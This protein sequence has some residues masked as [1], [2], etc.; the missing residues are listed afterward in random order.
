MLQ[1]YH[2]KEKRALEIPL[3]NQ[4]KY[5]RTLFFASKTYFYLWNV[6]NIGNIEIMNSWNSYC[7]LN[8]LQ[9]WC[10]NFLF[11]VSV[12]VQCAFICSVKR[13]LAFSNWAGPRHVQPWKSVYLLYLKVN[14]LTVNYDNNYKLIWSFS[15]SYLCFCSL[16]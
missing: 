4:W 15:D 12:N 1:G 2:D 8:I 10:K 9:Q 6:Y 11:N 16:L 7:K 13:N 14:N 5:K 3:Q